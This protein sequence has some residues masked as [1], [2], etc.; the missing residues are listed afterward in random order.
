MIRAI[1]IDDEPLALE[2]LQAHASRSGIIVLERT[3]TRASLG[4]SYLLQHRPDALFL[5][6]RMP[7]KS[8]IELAEQLPTDIPIVFTTAYPEHAVKG[9]ELRAADYLLKP[10]SFS[11][12]EQACTRIAERL[13]EGRQQ[14][15]DLLVRCNGAWIKVR[16]HAIRYIE[17][18]GNYLLLATTTGDHLIRQT[19]QEMA[20]RLPPYFVRTHK[21]YIVNSRQIDKLGAGTVCIAGVAIPVSTVYQHLLNPGMGLKR[22]LT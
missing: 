1:A 18:R 12:F 17:A 21:S 8:G 19:L 16:C 14:D 10:I 15:D 9:F 6:I 11:R 20:Q 13:Q 3:F 2:V 4:I 7:D 22:P 5:D